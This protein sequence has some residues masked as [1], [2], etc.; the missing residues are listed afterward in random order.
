MKIAVVTDSLSRKAGGL[1][2]SV[3]RLS[4]EMHRLGAVVRVFGVEDEHTQADAQHWLPLDVHV[5]PCRGPQAFGYAPGLVEGLQAFQPDSIQIHGIWQYI[6]LAVWSASRKSDCPYVVNPH[7]MLDPWAMTEFH[8]EEAGLRAGCTGCRHLK[9]A[10]CLRALCPSEADSIRKFGL[11]NPVCVVPNAIDVPL[12]LDVQSWGPSPFP[13]DRR[14]L[15]YLGRIHPKKGLTPL[16]DAWADVQKA[17]PSGVDPWVLAIAG[18]EQGIHEQQLRQRA[19]D[20]GIT[21]SVA[22]LGPQFDERKAACY[23]YCDAFVLPSFSEGLPMV[24]LEAWAYGKPVLITPECNLPQGFSACAAIRIETSVESIAAGIRELLTITPR[25]REEIGKLGLSLVQ[26]EYSWPKVAKM[27]LTVQEWVAYG[28][29][30]PESI[31][32]A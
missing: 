19:V 2:E 28:G 23:R 8:L 18:W 11:R 7:G 22:F 16:L 26:E 3:R 31:L 25:Q 32:E 9:G 27:M 4:Q 1:F 14:I 20:L 10:A 5:M 13:R 21:Q 30:I 24:V 12:A 15:L 17:P 29:P 6:S